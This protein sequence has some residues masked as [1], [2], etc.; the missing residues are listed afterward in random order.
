MVKVGGVGAA[1]ATLKTSLVRLAIRIAV[2]V[3]GLTFFYG[4]CVARVR[5]NE[6]GVEQ[7]KFGFKKGIV[8]RTYAP[9]LYFV[10]PGTTMHTFPREIHVLEATFDLQDALAKAHDTTTEHKVEQ[11]FE[12]RDEELGAATHR[13]IQAINVQ[14]S[15]GYA[16][17][18]DLTLSPLII[19]DKSNDVAPR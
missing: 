12:R 18:G 8:E 19:Y 1:A 17:I 2:V 16:V 5:P 10:G 15:D 14:T 11:Y 3:V 9:G 13:T 4:A 7:R 6:F